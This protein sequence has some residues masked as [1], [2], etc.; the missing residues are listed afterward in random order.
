MAEMGEGEVHEGFQCKAETGIAEANAEFPGCLV[1]FAAPAPYHENKFGRTGGHN[2][3]ALTLGCTP[4]PS[5]NRTGSSVI[6][7]SE[8]SL[9]A[10]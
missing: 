6:G 9:I 4:W 7:R 1:R 5:Q 8:L 10:I 2:E 3:S